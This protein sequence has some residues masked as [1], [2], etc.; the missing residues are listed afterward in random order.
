MSYQAERAAEILGR[1]SLPA[2]LSVE[3]IATLQVHD[4]QLPELRLREDQMP[5]AEVFRVLQRASL[6]A[7]WRKAIQRAI[8]SG[9]LRQD[10]GKI[11]ATEFKRWL[12]VQGDSPS[13]LI[14][15]WFAL[16]ARERKA[17]GGRKWTPGK[18]TP[19]RKAELRDYRERHGTRAAAQKY[20]ISDGRVRQLLPQE[21]PSQTASTLL[22]PEKRTMRK[23]K[24]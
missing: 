22:M 24:A 1:E 10:D 16:H 3:E 20:G 13:T 11:T 2:A 21:P 15:S 19:E 7:T 6:A 18:W 17:P 14:Q 23:R 9:E 8:D 5:M 12:D 4:E